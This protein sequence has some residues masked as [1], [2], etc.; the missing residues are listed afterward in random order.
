MQADL[1][2][3]NIR[4]RKYD[5]GDKYYAMPE[6]AAKA[7]QFDKDTEKSFFDIVE[8]HYVLKYVKQGDN[9]LDVGAGTGRLSVAL[10]KAGANVVAVDVNKNRLNCIEEPSIK[11]VVI[12]GGE[13]LP[14]D[15]CSFDVV[16][17]WNLMV[18]IRR[19]KDF[20]R[21]HMR[22][23][24]PGGYIIY[25]MFNND[26][27]RLVS[28]NPEIYENYMLYS[29]DS[30]STINR[31]ELE[32]A[33]IQIGG[34]ELMEMIPYNFFCQ[35]AFSYGILTRFES[36]DLGSYYD[37]LCGNEKAAP[38]IKQFENEIVSKLP[39]DMTACNICVFK[40]S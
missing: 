21:E 17:A 14:F 20:L 12:D 3:E 8:K 36:R 34:I 37:A 9:V 31:S 38:I 19:W 7:K 35:T 26:H 4:K 5:K 18:H 13:R 40:K 16:T 32:N 39:E 30:Y 6:N 29:D 27:L 10:F 11:K 1:I 23:V 15:D 22:V 25:N 24:K 33:C 2:W 28:S